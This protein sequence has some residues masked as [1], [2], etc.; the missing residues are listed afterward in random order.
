MTWTKFN[1]ALAQRSEEE[2][3]QML[4]E[5]VAKHKRPTF[6]VRLHQRYSA[7]RVTRERKELLAQVQNG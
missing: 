2:V 7:L 1:A 5:E 6:V 4:D 3:K